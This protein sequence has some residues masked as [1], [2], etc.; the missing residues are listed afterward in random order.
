[1]YPV[2]SGGGGGGCNE[3]EQ[4]QFAMYIPHNGLPHR[5]LNWQGQMA[6][7]RR[8]IRVLSL[9][10][11]VLSASSF[12]PKCAHALFRGL[13]SFAVVSLGTSSAVEP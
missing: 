2:L 5:R 7:Y 8:F 4:S 11:D 12:E 10:P 1:M 3:D 13:C 6:P 9:V